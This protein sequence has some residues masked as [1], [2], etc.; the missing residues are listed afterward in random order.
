MSGI[1]FNSEIAW[2]AF[3]YY[4]FFR[5][6]LNDSSCSKLPFVAFSFTSSFNWN[7]LSINICRHIIEFLY[8]N[9]FAEDLHSNM[10]K[11]SGPVQDGMGEK[12]LNKSGLCIGRDLRNK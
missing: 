5:E 1:D 4:A 2:S 11:A 6:L 7:K 12:K 9:E 8:E 3:L 10:R